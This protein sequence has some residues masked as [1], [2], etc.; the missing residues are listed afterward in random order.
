MSAGNDWS[1]G[2]STRR[3]AATGGIISEGE[4]YYAALAEENE[5]FVRRD[6]SAAAW[7]T[8]DRSTLFSWWKTKL[9]PAD[10]DKKRKRLVIDIEA[11]YAFFR[12]LEEAVEPRRRLFRYILALILVRKRALRLDDIAKTPDGDLLLVY[13]R[14]AEKTLKIPAP[15]T[16]TD[17]IADV[18]AELARLFEVNESDLA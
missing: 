11:F 2:R 1:V 7:P 15:E 6:F 8:V 10:P 3:C 4:A 5:R 12:E 14:R 17:D 18:E 13:D 16:T 9:T